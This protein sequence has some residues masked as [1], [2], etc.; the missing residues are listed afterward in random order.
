MVTHGRF[1]LLNHRARRDT[2]VCAT[3]RRDSVRIGVT[4]AGPPASSFL[5]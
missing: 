5:Y 1:S 2:S 3:A 4:V